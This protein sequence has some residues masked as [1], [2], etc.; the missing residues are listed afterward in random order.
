MLAM[1]A[2]PR[3]ACA[4]CPA[5]RTA[6]EYPLYLFSLTA[7]EILQVADISR[8]SR[9]EAGELIGYQRPRCATT[10]RRS[11]TTSTATR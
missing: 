2:P 7:Q 8:V 4:P 3:R 5:H 11:S 1:T 9:D 10:S 6:T